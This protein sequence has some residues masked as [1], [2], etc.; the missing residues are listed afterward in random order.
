MT[1]DTSADARKRSD[2]RSRSTF[3]KALSRN[4]SGRF[5]KSERCRFNTTIKS[6]GS[7]QK[8]DVKRVAKKQHD[9]KVREYEKLLKEDRIN[10]INEKRK[11]SEQNKKMKEINERKNETVQI[12]NNPVKIKRMKKKQLRMLAKRDVMNAV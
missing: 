4:K 11:R 12:I 10:R 7:K 2:V 1:N 8:C 9:L 6:K 5:W 3:T